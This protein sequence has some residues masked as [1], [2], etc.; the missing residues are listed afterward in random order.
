MDLNFCKAFFMGTAKANTTAEGLDAYKAV[1]DGLKISSSDVIV[2]IGETAEAKGLIGPAYFTGAL[3]GV[4]IA[5]ASM[6]DP[7]FV[8]MVSK[9]MK[10]EEAKNEQPSA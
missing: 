6:H 7:V 9:K 4:A 10:E 8:Q 2:A 5:Y 1:F 3:F